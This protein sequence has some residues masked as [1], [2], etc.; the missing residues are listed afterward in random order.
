MK[1]N[2]LYAF[3]LSCIFKIIFKVFNKSPYWEC[4]EAIIKYM[5]I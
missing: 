2:K 3:K 4:E 1:A 5:I